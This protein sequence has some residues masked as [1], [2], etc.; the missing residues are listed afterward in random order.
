VK[1]S[2]LEVTTIED[3]RSGIE[4]HGTGKYTKLQ[5]D[6]IRFAI[7]NISVMLN[8]FSC[9]EAICGGNNTFFSDKGSLYFHVYPNYHVPLAL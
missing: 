4:T 8:V 1:E 9:F 6:D 2:G 3:I 7:C 5:C